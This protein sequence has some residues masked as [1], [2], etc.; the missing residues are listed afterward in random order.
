V[1]NLRQRFLDLLERHVQK[2]TIYGNRASGLAPCHNDRNPSFHAD[3]EKCTWYCFACARGGGVKDFAVLVGEPWLESL[4][5]THHSALARRQAKR[6]AQA[7]LKRRREE[8]DEELLE[9]HRHTHDMKV[10]AID[11]L[12]L[13]HRHPELEE[14]FP[15]LLDAMKQ[16]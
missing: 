8:R 11:I 10:E 4:T 5:R 15:G 13:F 7:I 3:L 2:L 9:Q 14:E 1:T 16:Q 6:E 12:G